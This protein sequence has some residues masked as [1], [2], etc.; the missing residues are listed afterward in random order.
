MRL[1][2]REGRVRLH[3]ADDD[4]DGIVR[5]VPRVGELL[6]HRARRPVERGFR[7]QRIVGVR[8]ALEE[9][10]EELRVE[11]VLRVRE[12]LRD[13]LLD[14]PAL[15]PP[16]GFAVGDAAHPDG[17]DAKG[18]VEVL[19]GH[20]EHVL[21]H[22]LL[23]GGVELAAHGRA[24]VGELRGRELAAAAEHHVLL[25]VRHPG[26]A[27]GRLVGPDEVV[28]RR[29]HHGRQRIPDDHHLE[30]VVEGGAQDLARAGVGVRR[31]RTGHG[32]EQHD[33][34]QEE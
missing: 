32:R 27:G 21:R 2:P 8:R 33:G 24:Q 1:D 23:R 15:L 22:R 9:G 34:D 7:A 26:E 14:G 4:E 28:H 19:G 29:R 3:V 11:E 17:L 6:E 16:R 10:G 5:R 25:R 20:R 30:A 18:D 12:V 31:A 13:L